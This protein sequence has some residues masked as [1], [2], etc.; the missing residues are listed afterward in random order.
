MARGPFEPG[1]SL[2]SYPSGILVERVRGR[3]YVAHTR[4]REVSIL[5]LETLERIGVLVVG[6]GVDGLA[7][8]G[9]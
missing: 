8:S 3:I 1:D 6:Y 2:G 7:Y 5:D 4:V 9:L